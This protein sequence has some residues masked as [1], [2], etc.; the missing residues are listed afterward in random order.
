MQ[1]NGI[2]CAQAGKHR[3]Q[4]M[5]SGKA[6]YATERCHGAA[7]MPSR[8]YCSERVSP[9]RPVQLGRAHSRATRAPAGTL[10]HSGRGSPAAPAAGPHSAGVPATKHT[11]TTGAHFSDLT[12]LTDAGLRDLPRG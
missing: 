7:V 2:P 8:S 3:E 9:L 11:T 5:H 6:A 12:R 1:R 10:G 4:H